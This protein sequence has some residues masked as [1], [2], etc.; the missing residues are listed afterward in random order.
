MVI[1]QG[2]YDALLLVPNLISSD[3]VNLQSSGEHSYY[4]LVSMYNMQSILQSIKKM[5]MRMKLRL[6]QEKH[7]KL[8]ARGEKRGEIS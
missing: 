8:I 3:V 2:Q 7:G 4:V 1:S 5:M 6:P